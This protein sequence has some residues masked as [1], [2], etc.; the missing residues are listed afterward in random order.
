MF[1]L[2]ETLIIRESLCITFIIKS[3]SLL[4]VSIQKSSRDTNFH[5]ITNITNRKFLTQWQEKSNLRNFNSISA[6]I[7][8]VRWTVKPS[9]LHMIFV[10][11]GRILS[12]APF[13][14]IICI[15]FRLQSTLII[16]RSRVNSKTETCHH[17][18]F[19]TIQLAI[20]VVDLIICW[21]RYMSREWPNKD[22]KTKLSR[23]ASFDS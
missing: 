3:T 13:E 1:Y 16:F 19:K 22:N 15:C 4:K 23:E 14:N 8:G 21:R 11:L 20:T 5:L 17:A 9:S 7:S 10:H 18:R 12:G 6:L 2:I